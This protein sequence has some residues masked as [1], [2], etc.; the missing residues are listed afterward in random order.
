MALVL[1]SQAATGGPNRAQQPSAPVSAS[2]AGQ[3]PAVKA[4]HLTKRHAGW[5]Q[6]TCFDCHDAASMARHHQDASRLVVTS[7]GPCHGYNGAPDAVHAV[8]IN[9]CGNCHGLVAHAAQFK[10]PAD[11]IACHAHPGSPTGK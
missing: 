1:G 11:C 10:A 8:A 4:A 9:P 6:V 5:R 3:A 2:V 7:C